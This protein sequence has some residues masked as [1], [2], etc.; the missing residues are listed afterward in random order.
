LWQDVSGVDI[1]SILY[2]IFVVE[3]NH[4]LES[5]AEYSV[6][7][8]A[9]KLIPQHNFI[10]LNSF[11]ERILFT[12]D[13][14]HVQF[15][16]KVSLLRLLTLK[17]EALVPDRSSEINPDCLLVSPLE[18]TRKEFSFNTLSSKN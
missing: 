15:M 13:E 10:A 8:S 5:G 18:L 7:P 16:A 4:C 12:V 6:K 1:S 9:L 17:V 14:W 2:I 3:R 11:L